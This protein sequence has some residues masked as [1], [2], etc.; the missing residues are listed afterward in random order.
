[1]NLNP[2]GSQ[3]GIP[4]VD[5]T[6]KKKKKKKNSSKSGNFSVSLNEEGAFQG[7]WGE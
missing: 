3:A 2:A 5:E 1:V 4:T 6:V 7:G